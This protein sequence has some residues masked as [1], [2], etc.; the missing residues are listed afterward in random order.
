MDHTAPRH[1]RDRKARQR[2]SGES[3]DRVD[4]VL[5]DLEQQLSVCDEGTG[6]AGRKPREVHPGDRESGSGADD[7]FSDNFAAV[8]WLEDELKA[9]RDGLTA[10][11]E[12][13]LQTEFAALKADFEDAL[14]VARRAG[15]AGLGRI[16]D[17]LA[18][19]VERLA[20]RPEVTSTDELREEVGAIRH[21]LDVLAQSETEA[22]A[23]RGKGAPTPAPGGDAARP[24]RELAMLAGQLGQIRDAIRL[25]PDAAAIRSL[26]GKFRALAQAVEQFVQARA[27]LTPGSMQ[28]VGKRLDE[29]VRAI[30]GHRDGIERQEIAR[31]EARLASLAEQVDELAAQGSLSGLDKLAERMDLLADAARLP[32]EAVESLARRVDALSG[33]LEQA[34]AN[35]Q[36]LGR[37]EAR[38]DAIAGMV[39][40]SGPA[41]AAGN[42]RILAAVE[43]GFSAVGRQIDG[44]AVE[45]LDPQLLGSLERQLAEIGR[46]LSVANPAAD[47]PGTEAAGLDEEQIR[48]AAREAA[49][50]AVR[51]LPSSQAA[52]PSFDLLAQELRQLEEIARQ[53]EERNS[54]TFESVHDTLLTIIDRLSELERVGPDRAGPERDWRLEPIVDDLTVVEPGSG[55]QDPRQVRWRDEAHAAARPDPVEAARRAA[56]MARQQPDAAR[57]HYADDPS[58]PPP[59]RR[60]GLLARGQIATLFGIVFCLFVFSAYQLGKQLLVNPADLALELPGAGSGQLEVPGPAVTLA[61]A[62]PDVDGTGAPEIGLA[63]GKDQPAAGAA[64]PRSPIAAAIGPQSLREAAERNDPKALY[65]IGARYADGLGMERDPREAA[66]WFGRAA[67]LGSAP[68][69]Y[70]L[71]KLY[72]KGLL[73][74][75]DLARAIELYR[76]AA[77]QGSASAMHDLGVLFATSTEKG[78]DNVA[79]AHWF[80]RAAE[81]GVTDSQYNIGILSASGLGTDLDLVE[82]WKWFALAAS[83]GDKVALGKREEIAARMTPEELAEAQA[84]FEAWRPSPAS[85]EANRV[86][87]PDEWKGGSLNLAGGGTSIQRL[88]DPNGKDLGMAEATLTGR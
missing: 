4:R 3:L 66:R 27:D 52:H 18:R 41:A 37:L 35:L 81:L 78:P 80:R 8:Q 32:A 54:R 22:M 73:G 29:I 88:L 14:E 24:A 31:I 17:R 33:K 76:Q 6:E 39:A 9:L 84:R 40:A 57:E 34:V 67:D 58:A 60:S 28:W 59:R 53:S 87:L 45:G 16:F 49:E 83:A 13:D 63:A 77:A 21:E 11:A 26:E 61:A 55:S 70:R 30:A 12:P 51:A 62:H 25:L 19:N 86:E 36:R 43:S 50:A 56:R 7:P 20:S 23:R 64:F 15:G 74:K 46:Q 42:E 1:R 44:L 72:E 79:A 69:R 71:G 10:E 68:A 85:P 65:A 47:Q 48:E 5:S 75:R 2:P 38:L 82:S